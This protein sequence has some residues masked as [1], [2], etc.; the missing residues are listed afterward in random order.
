MDVGPK[1]VSESCR[2]GIEMSLLV[3][4]LDHFKKINDTYGHAKGDVVLA[5]VGDALTRGSRKEDIVAR[6][7]GEEFVVVYT[8]CDFNVLFEAA[9]TAAYKSKENGRN[10][11]EFVGIKKWLSDNLRFHFF[12]FND[13]FHGGDTQFSK[14]FCESFAFESLFSEFL[15]TDRVGG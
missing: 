3:I 2:H 12:R 8:H 7:G 14:S 4:D 1:K 6:F 5:A 15:A 13:F 10:R 9:D 11:V